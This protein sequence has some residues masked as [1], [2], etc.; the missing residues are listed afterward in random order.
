MT[1]TAYAAVGF[2]VLVTA[3]AFSLDEPAV[4]QVPLS[5]YTEHAKNRER[6]EDVASKV[7]L[8]LITTAQTNRV[9]SIDEVLEEVCK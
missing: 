7:V 5:D 3:I 2:V 6:C 4:P 9:P 8:H 1:N